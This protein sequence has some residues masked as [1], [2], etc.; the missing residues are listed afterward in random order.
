M[1]IYELTTHFGRLAPIRTNGIGSYLDEA[2]RE[3]GLIGIPIA[4]ISEPPPPP[5]PPPGMLSNL[6]GLNFGAQILPPYNALRLN[7]ARTI[8]RLRCLR[9]LSAIQAAEVEHGHEIASLKELGLP[10]SAL[11][12]PFSGSELKFHRVAKGWVVYSV[13]DDLEDDDGDLGN[14]DRKGDVGVG[15]EMP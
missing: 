8:A 4:K 14:I 9:I 10:P 12:D 5:P 3:L 13:G 7:T 1:G 11:V 2:D 15:P 6:L